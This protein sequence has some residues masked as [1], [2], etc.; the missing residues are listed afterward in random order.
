VTYV[1]AIAVGLALGTIFRWWALVAAAAFGLW[2][3]LTTGVDEVPEW[4][5]GAGYALLVCLGVALGI[6]ARRA[7]RGSR[8]SEQPSLD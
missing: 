2:V 1:A 7:L 5:L 4:L 3:S 8:D 6:G